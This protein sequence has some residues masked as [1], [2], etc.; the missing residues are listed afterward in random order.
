MIMVYWDGVVNRVAGHGDWM[1]CHSASGTWIVDSAAAYSKYITAQHRTIEYSTDEA[2]QK[3]FFLVPPPQEHTEPGAGRRC[4]AQIHKMDYLFL[5]RHEAR[6]SRW[7]GEERGIKLHGQ[8]A[9]VN[10]R[11]LHGKT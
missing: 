9:I 1:V 3:S 5:C 11:G 2:E 10:W 8:D 6:E 7:S 4:S